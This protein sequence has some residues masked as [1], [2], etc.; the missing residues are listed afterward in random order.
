MLQFSGGVCRRGFFSLYS[1][2]GESLFGLITPPADALPILSLDD[3]FA[4]TDVLGN[5]L[6]CWGIRGDSVLIYRKIH[7]L[8]F[9]FRNEIKRFDLKGNA[10]VGSYLVDRV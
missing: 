10:V 6:G 2:Y 1:T 9:G 5:E 3:A 4:V 8:L 7:V